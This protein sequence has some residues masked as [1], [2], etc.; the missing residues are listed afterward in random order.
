[1]RQFI[2]MHKVLPSG[3]KTERFIINHNKLSKER[4]KNNM[5][6]AAMD[7]NGWL[8][9]GLRAN[10]PYCVLIEKGRKSGDLIT[11]ETVWMSDTPMEQ[12]TCQKFIDNANGKVLILGL[13]IG[14]VIMPLLKDPDIT[15]IVVIEKEQELINLIT[16]YIRHKKL[17][18]IQGDACEYEP[19][20]LYD[21]VILDIWANICSDNYKD[22]KLLEKRYRKFMVRKKENPNRYIDSW[23]KE[24]I[25]KEAR[26]EI[27]HEKI[28]DALRGTSN[29][30]KLSE[31][32]N[33]PII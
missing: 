27:Q 3:I 31:A 2:E 4:V 18:I 7:G 11:S 21:T 24:K 32:L 13:G 33:N 14:M 12:N 6:Y 26:E 17:T 19:D 15:Q 16:P 1:M 10:F 28:M 5:F 29:I 8:Y 20:Q 23:S 22:M 25:I 9:R 30:N